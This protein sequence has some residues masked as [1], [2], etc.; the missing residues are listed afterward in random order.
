MAAA[1]RGRAA[2]LAGFALL[3][4]AQKHERT[5]RA[6]SALFLDRMRTL[7]LV[8]LL[9]AVPGLA[10]DFWTDHPVSA[11]DQPA[12][13]V[14]VFELQ[15]AVAAEKVKTGGPGG[16]WCKLR[17]GKKEGWVLCREA[18][19]TGAAPREKTPRENTPT[20]RSPKPEV[21]LPKS[22]PAPVLRTD[23]S[24]ARCDTRCKGPALFATAPPLS[25][26]AKEVLALCP[27]DASSAVSAAEVRRFFAA[28]HDDAR[29]QRAL[30]AAG[31]AGRKEDNLDWLTSLWVGSGPR[32]A[33][34]HVLMDFPPARA[35]L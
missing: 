3:A 24:G 22:S 8:L 26:E 1:H 28:H 30:S 25:A 12:G 18:R 35:D 6:T 15:P 10:A 9:V 2:A 16:T 14:V 19:H 32:N 21:T 29:L 4:E 5:A 11:L 23:S 17:L 31:R 34:T 13:K 20:E 33:F 27:T 7:T